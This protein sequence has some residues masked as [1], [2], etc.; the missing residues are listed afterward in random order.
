MLGGLAAVGVVGFVGKTL[1]SRF[2]GDGDDAVGAVPAQ[3]LRS[4][5]RT[6]LHGD[7]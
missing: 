2:S 5:G 1:L 6:R 4:A 3:L 7:H